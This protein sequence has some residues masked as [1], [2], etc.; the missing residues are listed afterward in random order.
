MRPQ[1]FDRRVYIV[2][3]DEA[4][5]TTIRRILTDAGVYTQEF[6]SAEAL[7]ENYS[8]RPPGCV[9]VDLRLPGMNGLELLDCIARSKPSN[10]VIMLSGHGDIPSAVQAVQTGALDFLQKPF[11][12][13]KLLELVNKA[14]ELLRSRRGKNTDR[15]ERLS[16]REKE[17]LIAFADGASNK[18]VARQM[19]VSVRTVE[20]HRA[21][22]M[23]KLE[24]ANLTQALFLARDG[25]LID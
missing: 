18:E 3:D 7:L 5:R 1:H 17:M 16:T 8:A 6:G 4:L 10:P 23:R 22:L 21:N 20:M 25:G 14:F 12:K 24:V 11:R 19:N 9:I 13:E 2:D 15:L